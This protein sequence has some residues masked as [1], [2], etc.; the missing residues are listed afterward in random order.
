M[1]F[2]ALYFLG[3]LFA[4]GLRLP[5]RVRRAG[6]KD[7]GNKPGSSR[8]AE[9]LV[10]VA[11]A[12]G[13]WLLPAMYALTPALRPFDYGLPAWMACVGCAVFAVSL[14]L[15]LAAQLTLSRSWSHTLETTQEQVLVQ[16]GVYG[17][18]RHPLY[19][20][21]IFWA[22]AQPALLQNGL[23]GFGGAVAVALIWLVR[24]PREEQLM[25]DTFGE[26]YRRYMTRTGKV[27]TLRREQRDG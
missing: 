7:R 18:S 3:L 22:L 25:L 6:S 1:S 15:R 9:W 4:E 5:Q 12:L 19:V 24:V 21:L 2:T 10:L 17:I 14:A 13:M 20:S 26:D 16:H 23:A 8:T 11:V 27:V